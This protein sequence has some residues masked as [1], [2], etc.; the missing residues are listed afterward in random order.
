LK[1]KKR[2]KLIAN[3]QV[4]RFQDFQTKERIGSLLRVL[5]RKGASDFPEIGV[6]L[7]ETTPRHDLKAMSKLLTDAGFTKEGRSKHVF[8]SNRFNVFVYV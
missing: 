3:P 6:Y 2:T 1:V 5:T 4:T 7:Q 8:R